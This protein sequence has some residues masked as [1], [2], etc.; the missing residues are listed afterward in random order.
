MY[1]EGNTN[2]EFFNTLLTDFLLPNLK[3]N[4]V[5]IMDN[6]SFHKGKDIEE[7]FKIHEINL[8]YLPP[9]SPDLNQIEK[10]WRQNMVKKIRDQ[11]ADF[12]DCFKCVLWYQ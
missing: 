8:M 1:F 6:A 9:Y 12:N 5:V 3:K 4:Q 11:F 7:M 2:T 10:K